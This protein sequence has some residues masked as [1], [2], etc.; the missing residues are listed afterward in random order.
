MPRARI[1]IRPSVRLPGVSSESTTIWRI[2]RILPINSI[3]RVARTG[4]RVE[5]PQLLVGIKNKSAQFGIFCLHPAPTFIHTLDRCVTA[6]TSV[7]TLS[8]M[9]PRFDRSSAVKTEIVAD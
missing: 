5:E 8:K 2:L 3:V 4:E 9:P 1:D 6:L 7:S